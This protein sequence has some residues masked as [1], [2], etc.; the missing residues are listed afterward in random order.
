M[1]FALFLKPYLRSIR[2]ILKYRSSLIDPRAQISLDSI[3]RGNNYVG[4]HASVMSS[5][6]GKYSYV[7]GKSELGFCTIGRYVSIAPS[8]TIGLQSHDLTKLS[9]FPAFSYDNQIASRHLI[10]AEQR[11]Y[12]YKHTIVD[13]DVWIGHSAL[14][15]AGVHIGIGSVVGAGSIVTK[16]LEPFGIYVGSPAKLMRKRFNDQLINTLLESR[17]WELDFADA[18][19]LLNSINV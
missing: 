2:A 7:G 9:T 5:I 1:M 17:W 19:N 12:S 3:L 8:V 11:S 6:I 4:P 13:A 18:S 10:S 14:I 16:D 15:M